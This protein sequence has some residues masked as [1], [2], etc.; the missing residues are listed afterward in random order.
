MFKWS[1]IKNA[2]PFYYTPKNNIIFQINYN[3]IKCK[4]SYDGNGA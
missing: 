2:K 3:S 1:I 4:V